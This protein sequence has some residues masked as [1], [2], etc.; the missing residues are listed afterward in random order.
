MTRPALKGQPVGY[1]VARYAIA[2]RRAFRIVRQY[3]SV[4][5]YSSCKDPRTALRARMRELAHVRT[6]Y[7]NRRLHILL[8]R[9]GWVLGREVACRLY[10]EESLQLRSKRPWRRKMVVARPDRYVPK[11]AN[12][13][14]SMDFVAERGL[15][16]RR[17]HS[18]RV[19][20][21]APPR[22]PQRRSTKVNSLRPRQLVH[23]GT[24]PTV[25]RLASG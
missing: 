3:R 12:Q 25:K 16:G 6:R 1:I 2:W 20:R 9:E 23:A 21:A 7:G 17:R 19:W 5:Y 18:R 10:T 24:P 4:Q 11:R 22:W 14:W 8:Q 13:A 15:A